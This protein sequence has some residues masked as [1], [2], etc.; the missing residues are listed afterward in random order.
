MRRKYCQY[1]TIVDNSFHT[2]P[3]IVPFSNYLT[4]AD[5]LELMPQTIKGEG[6]NLESAPILDKA[7]TNLEMKKSAATQVRRLTFHNCCSKDSPGWE[8]SG[9]SLDAGQAATDALSLPLISLP[10]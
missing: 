3:P 10:R 1:L 9:K 2:H 5:S 8:Y 6:I 7:D 4:G